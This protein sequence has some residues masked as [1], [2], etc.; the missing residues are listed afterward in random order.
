LLLTHTVWDLGFNDKMSILIVQR[1]GS[2]VR[3]IEYVEDSHR[4]LADY[5]ADLKAKPYNWGV[6]Y[7]PHD[8]AARDFKTGLSAQEV[9]QRLGRTVEIVPRMDIEAGIK[10][11][12]LIFPRVYFDEERAAGLLDRLKRY[13]RAISTTTGEAGAPIHDDASHGADAFRYMALVADQMANSAP[14]LGDPYKQ[15][16]NSWHG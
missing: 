1:L 16:R 10:A 7:L 4:T 8:G 6:D 2:E 14:T 3:V 11:A 5:V 13:K 15:F 9:L 12:R